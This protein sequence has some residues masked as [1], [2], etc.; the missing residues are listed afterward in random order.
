MTYEFKQP[1]S[2]GSAVLY[3][4]ER[5]A[6]RNC[7]LSTYDEWDFYRGEDLKLIFAPEAKA[8]RA[9][10]KRSTAAFHNHRKAFEPA[11]RRARNIWSEFV[12][13]L[14]RVRGLEDPGWDPSARNAKATVRNMF[15]RSK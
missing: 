11:F 9:G 4:I 3:H 14:I 6:C 2:K 8:D 12:S 5:K 13:L 7:Q 15:A 10:F 1:S